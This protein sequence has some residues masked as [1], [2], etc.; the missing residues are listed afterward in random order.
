MDID[1][2]TKEF[3][4]LSLK[5]TNQLYNNVHATI[6]HSNSS[7]T[8]EL[9]SKR[10]KLFSKINDE[11]IH[12]KDILP[13]KST[14]TTSTTTNVQ[15]K[16][17]SMKDTTIDNIIS[18]QPNIQDEKRRKVGDSNAN[19]S[20]VVSNNNNGVKKMNMTEQQKALVNIGSTGPALSYTKPM[21]H[22]PWK[23]MRVVAGH[24]G[25]VRTISVDVN[26]EFF[27]TGATDNTIKVWDMASGE[28]KVTLVYHIAP[29]RAVQLSARHPYMF[30]AG[31]D[32]KV[33]CWDLEANR[34]IRHY[35][36]HRNGVYSLALH[37]SLDIIFTGGKDSTVR[38]WDMRTKAEIYTLSGHK[39][40]VGSLIS[41]SPDPQVISGSMD[42]TI[43]LWD[44]KT[45][46][47][48]VT[49]TNHKKSV[50]GLV[51]HEKEFSFASGSADNIKQWKLPE[52]QFIKN[53]SGHNAI[54]NCL[55]LN[56]DNVLV[57]GGDNGSMQFWDWKTGYCF[58]KSQTIAQPGSLDS[59][60]GIFAMA[61]DR[62]GTRLITCEADK[63]IKVYKEDEEANESTH[64][65]SNEWRPTAQNIKRF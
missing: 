1:I 51:M 50:R 27:V 63:S 44:L 54:I 6:A 10:I 11:Y 31:E 3:C 42:N 8:D 59:E 17:I 43:R 30:S 37:P 55:A 16:D 53:L 23:L 22:P 26:N 57:S 12:V 61:F 64:P 19:M 49:L 60:A 35:H 56:Q 14:T 5:N 21:W 28:L 47:S 36:G 20:I 45:G 40:T 13:P 7:A 2:Q 15:S 41:Q 46:Q 58:Q 4:K 33:I 24:T 29:V 18:S 48:A 39:G 65:I 52:G 62:T 38:V 32:N 34:P 25:W 9:D